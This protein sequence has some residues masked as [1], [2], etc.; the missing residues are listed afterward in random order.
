MIDKGAKLTI[1]IPGKT[2]LAGEYL[3]LAGGPSIVLA[4]RPLFEITFFNVQW[5]PAS[6]EGLRAEIA[7]PPGSPAGRFIRAHPENFAQTKILLKDP[8]SG[9]G[10][11][12]ASTAQFAAVYAY[13]TFAETARNGKSSNENIQFDFRDENESAFWDQLLKSYRLCAWSGEGSPP[14]GADLVGQV[15]GGIN[16]FDEHALKS[17]K[18]NWVFDEIEF[19]LLRTGHKLA[20]HEH[21][22]LTNVSVPDDPEARFIAKMKEAV[23]NAVK[24]LTSGSDRDLCVAVRQAATALAENNRVADHTKK[25]LLEL[26]KTDFVRAAKG[27]GAMGADILLVVHDGSKRALM[28]KWA[29]DHT[30]AICGTTTDLT[31]SGLQVQANS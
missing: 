13:A 17:K 20:T 19:T 28:E 29:R 11:L 12:G 30:L 3:A 6:G 18:F 15:A 16:Y 14:S 2:F 23:A 8:H 9:L 21:L 31:T 5:Q 26:E 10:G 22:K 1:S 25:I 4:T 24:A 27:C 7:F